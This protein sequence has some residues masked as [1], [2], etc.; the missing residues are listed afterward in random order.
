MASSELRRWS[1]LCYCQTAC[2]RCWCGQDQ[3]RGLQC[4]RLVH[5]LYQPFIG[6]IRLIIIRWHVL[7]SCDCLP[8]LDLL[9]LGLPIVRVFHF[10][11]YTKIRACG[12]FYYVLFSRSVLVCFCCAQDLRL[13][14]PVSSFLLT[15]TKLFS[16]AITCSRN[17]CRWSWFSKLR[18]IYHVMLRRRSVTWTPSTNLC[19]CA[20][21]SFV[22]AVHHVMHC[23]RVSSEI[24]CHD[25][26]KD[27]SWMSLT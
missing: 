13:S 12:K 6:S 17:L 4:Y 27:V 26:P 7:T 23:E 9:A 22:F 11:C 21:C 25:P 3:P 20:Q 19:T 15:S 18:K 2:S 8:F 24:E 14:A 16:H 1:R 5:R 10:G